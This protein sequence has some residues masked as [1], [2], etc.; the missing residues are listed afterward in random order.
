MSHFKVI[1]P[2]L[3]ALCLT[4]TGASSAPGVECT[5]STYNSV[6]FKEPRIE[7]SPY[8]K[9]FARI[10]CTGLEVGEQSMHANWIHKDRGLIRSD[11]HRFRMDVSGERLVF[12]W[13]KLTRKG[14]LSSVLT[15]KDFHEDNFGAWLVEIYLNDTLVGSSDFQILPEGR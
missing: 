12:F 2:G 13:F 11:K 5:V 10:L 14:P 7:F 15:N 4:L 9:I 8:E 3:F 1:L 6:E